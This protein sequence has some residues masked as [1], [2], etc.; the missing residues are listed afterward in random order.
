V[1]D[2]NSAGRNAPAWV[3]ALLVLAGLILIVIA[4]I[5]FVEPADKL[6][7]FFPGH[8]ANETRKHIKHGIGALVVGLIAFAGAWFS[9]GRK[10]A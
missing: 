3:T 6:P 8:S 9:T 4:V 10:V 7:G 2:G 1:T 5:Y